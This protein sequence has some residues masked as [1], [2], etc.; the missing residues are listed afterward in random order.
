MSQIVTVFIKLTVPNV[1]RDDEVWINPT[2][3]TCIRT[4]TNVGKKPVTVVS[5]TNKIQH[6]VEETPEQ[7]REKICNIHGVYYEPLSDGAQ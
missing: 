3:I 1:V 6:V 7:I 2:Q 5:L 4:D